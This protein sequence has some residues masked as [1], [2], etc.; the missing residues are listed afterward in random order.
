MPISPTVSAWMQNAQPQQGMDAESLFR[1]S[2]QEQAFNSLRSRAA[3]LL[4]YV[5][6]FR[7][8]DANLD[9][10]DAFGTFALSYG[11]DLVFIP[12]VMTAGSITSCEMAYLRSEDR[13][14]PL[15]DSTVQDIVNKN[16]GSLGEVM[17]KDVRVED[18]RRL[19]RNLIRPP[20]SS[21]VVL[22]SGRIDISE[23]PNEA[24]KQVSDYLNAHPQLLGKI[25]EFYPI[26]VLADRLSPKAEPPQTNSVPV[27]YT[28]ASISKE[29]AAELDEDE[30]ATLLSRGW[31]VK[32]AS[33]E[34]KIVLDPDSFGAE[35]ENLLS[36]YNYDTEKTHRREIVAGDILCFTG[37]SFVMVPSVI[38][39]A[40]DGGSTTVFTEDAVH[41]W[42]KKAVV[43]NEHCVT[44]Q[45]LLDFGFVPADRLRAEMHRFS[46]RLNRRNEIVTIYIV[47]PRKSGCWEYVAN[48][49][50]LSGEGAVVTLDNGDMHVLPLNGGN[51]ELL[52]TNGL[53]YGSYKA[54]APSREMIVPSTALF[55][56]TSDEERQGL[57]GIIPTM[58]V[59]F[60][61]LRSKGAVLR[62]NRAQGATN[63]TDNTTG[64][65]ASFASDGDAAAWLS[66]E[67]N[68]S[69]RQIENTLGRPQ[70]LVI[71]KLA[72]GF[73]QQAPMAP[74]PQQPMPPAPPQ[75]QQQLMPQGN[76]QVPVP[77]FNPANMQA[78]AGLNNPD[79]VD[80]GIL[81]SFAGDP[82]VRALLVDYMPDF[83]SVMDRIGRIILVFNLQRTELEKYYRTDKINELLQNCRRVFRIVGELVRALKV[84]INMA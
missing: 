29:A 42:L 53:T 3:R 68:L 8:L 47:V 22:A 25:A 65:T 64:K 36:E 72:A 57:P 21:N 83:L 37:G 44:R 30:K 10:G 51:A 2:F 19:F 55:R 40:Q 28:S 77:T 20:A 18:T 17:T 52:I 33:N 45:E 12:V 49:M 76:T 43:A 9:S 7:I 54:P 79:M 23:L 67:Y 41:D 4:S 81:A 80:V 26:E 69:E 5:V 15:Q 56:V 38:C 31:L 6:T 58:Q 74:A 73:M 32:G 11:S 70:S 61:I 82:D 24:K 84:Y 35:T 62:V 60:D 27:V 16:S 78:F 71:T 66:R 39:S 1:K 34:T 14:V 59:L 50:L 48:K 75:P 13:F 46:S 63:I